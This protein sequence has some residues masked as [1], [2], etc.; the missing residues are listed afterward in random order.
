MAFAALLKVRALIAL[1]CAGGA[2]LA[3]GIFHYQGLRFG[4]SADS[5]PY[6][7]GRVVFSF[8]LGVL[9]QRTRRLWASRLPVLDPWIIYLLVLGLLA[10]PKTPAAP[11]IVLHL[12]TV[13][14]LGPLL[15]MLGS[16]AKPKG[17][18]AK[19][20]VGL[21][22]VSYPL[23]AVHMPLIFLG[24]GLAPTFWNQFSP[25]YLCLIAA[26]VALAA[27]LP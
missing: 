24:A 5:V 27:V 11:Q 4:L 6:Y 22:A 17:F 16:V 10:I 12:A 26:V 18:T 8:F 15:V 23:Y 14:V 21:G 13:F 19:A 3:A 1:I 9:L 20:S 7:L 2:I 25:A